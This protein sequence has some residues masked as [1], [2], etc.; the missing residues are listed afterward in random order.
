MIYLMGGMWTLIVGVGVDRI[1]FL[2]SL[3]LVVTMVGI[4]KLTEELTKKK[5]MAVG[6]TIMFSLIPVIFDISRNMLLDLPL[7]GWV[8]WGLYF[9]VKSEDLQKWRYAWGWWLMLVAASLTKINGLI[10]FAPMVVWLTFRWLKNKKIGLNLAIL[11]L[12]YVI[13]VGWWWAINWQNIYGYLTGLASQG[14]KLTDPMNL[15]E[16]QTWLHYFKLFFLHQL[17]PIPTIIFLVSCWHI[18][19]VRLKN[20]GLLILFLGMNYVVFTAIKNKDFRFTMP[21][22]PVV[23]IFMMV[24]LKEWWNKNKKISIV[25]SSVLGLWLGM[26]F[27]STSFEWPTKKPASVITKTFLMGEIDWINITDYP[28]RSFKTTV[29]PQEKILTDL[30]T[31]SKTRGKK[32]S[33]LV[34]INKEEVNDNNLGMYKELASS[35]AFEPGSVGSRIAFES[36]GQIRVLLSGF[37]A[38]LV[39]DQTFDPAPFYGVNL[40][41]YRQARD[42]VWEHLED[43][44]IVTEY[45]VWGDKKLSLMVRN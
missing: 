4:Y 5:L 19:K 44:R 6:A 12:V 23:A 7:L 1:T 45:A 43:Y 11:G 22:L 27:L 13:A 39:P 30:D 28:V 25:L 40:E 20:M 33:T 32:L 26:Y 24:G 10:Y 2:N 15:W 14:E 18:D 9:L 38:F 29:W 16:W 17:S 34:L 21:L 37:D 8:V 41:A 31:L 35:Q 3:F 42:Y 36:E